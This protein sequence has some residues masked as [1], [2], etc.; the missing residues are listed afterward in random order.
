MSRK[1]FFSGLFVFGSLITGKACIWQ[2]QRKNW[3]E[4]LIKTRQAY[5][6]L[7]PESISFPL[8]D[9][10]YN[11]RPVKLKGKFDHKHEMHIMRNYGSLIGYKVLTP[12]YTEDNKGFIVLRGWVP[13]RFKDWSSR[14][15]LEAEVEVSGV[16]REGDKPGKLTP[17]N[18][19]NINEWHFIDL[20]HMADKCGLGNVEA[21]QWLVEEIS[22][23]RNREVYEGEDWPELPVKT[24]K[25]DLLQFTIMPYTHSAYA[26]FWFLSSFLCSC[27]AYVC[28]KR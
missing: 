1:Y 7:E 2:I 3:K 24:V 14:K 11:Y 9:K 17:E 25:S 23:S 13:S 4:D 6:D 26:T 28:F 27:F 18:L 15:D 8:P 10:D 16:L 20:K 19:E 22:W 5:I 12:F 21:R